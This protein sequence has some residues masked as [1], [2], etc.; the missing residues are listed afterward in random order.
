M[1]LLHCALFYVDL[2]NSNRARDD[3]VEYPTDKR[4]TQNPEV[5]MPPS[6]V[7]LEEFIEHKDV[8]RAIC[9]K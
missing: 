3:I 5:S 4:P 9:A 6:E 1:D 2:S 8:E 7:S